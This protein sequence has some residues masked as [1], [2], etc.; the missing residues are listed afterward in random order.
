MAVNQSPNEHE[1]ERRRG[2]GELLYLEDMPI[3]ADCIACYTVFTP[4]LT[5]AYRAFASHALTCVF[6][7][8]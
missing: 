3:F 8:E 2:Q 4:F 7:S 6:E 1:N 5:A